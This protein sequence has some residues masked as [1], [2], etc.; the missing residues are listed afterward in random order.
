MSLAAPP[1]DASTA[2]DDEGVVLADFSTIDGKPGWY[3]VNDNVMGG[4]SDGGFTIDEGILHFAGRTDTNGGGFSSIRTEAVEFDLSDYAGIRLRVNGDGRRYTWRLVTDAR[5]Q[6][7]E[8]AYWADFDTQA[9]RWSTTDIPFSRFEP[10]YRGTK[11]EGPELDPAK[12]TGMGLMIYD[13]LD[14]PFELSL[15][16]VHAFPAQAAFTLEEYRW[17]RRVLVISAP[18]QDD[19]GLAKM[20]DAVA[21]SIAEFTERDMVLVTLL[22]S[23]AS[24]AGERQLTDTEAAAVRDALGIQAGSFALRLVGKDGS[25][26]LSAESPAAMAE[27]YALI[28]TMPMRRSEM[29]ERQAPSRSPPR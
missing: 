8:I 27:I 2:R 19:A 11:L 12:I 16:A 7:R 6:G 9:G 18:Q 20:R 1:H 28:D 14:G 3:V 23:G 29:A 13:G 5:W 21:S 4:R 25:V 10:R 26:K 17:N 24:V 15:A 22:D